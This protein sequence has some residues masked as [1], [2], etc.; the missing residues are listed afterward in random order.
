MKSTIQSLTL[1]LATAYAPSINGAAMPYPEVPVPYPGD[2]CPPSCAKPLH[3]LNAGWDWA[4]YS[5]PLRNTGN[6]DYP[7]FSPESFKTK[8]PVYTGVTDTIGGRISDGTNGVVPV[9]G[10]SADLNATYFALNHHA[11]LYACESGAWQ[12]NVSGVDDG[13]YVWLGEPAYT[14]WTDENANAKAFWAFDN[15]TK[16]GSKSFESQLT[17]GQYYPLRVVFG[18]GLGIGSFNFTITSPSGIVVHQSG[19]DSDYL[20]RFSCD[21]E[22]SAPR[23]P[24]F[25]KET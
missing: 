20:V 3:C 23:F 16:L 2:L 7:G 4:Y 8:E 9:Y 25:G 14:G 19:T 24:E 22:Q 15:G 17:G 6:G 5:N 12:F 10:S 1:L 21:L 13:V 18:N 11:Y